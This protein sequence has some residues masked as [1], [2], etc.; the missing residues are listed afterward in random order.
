[1]RSPNRQISVIRDSVLGR[2]PLFI[3]LMHRG[4]EKAL[5]APIPQADGTLAVSA[6]LDYL[7]MAAGGGGEEI[8]SIESITL[9]YRRRVGV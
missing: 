7:R 2:V 8:D 6:P 1:M 3:E 5:P 9:H 4:N